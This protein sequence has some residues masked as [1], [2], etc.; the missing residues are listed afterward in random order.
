MKICAECKYFLMSEHRYNCNY[1]SKE[2]QNHITGEI[3]YE[4]KSC[5]E[6][7]CGGKCKYWEPKPKKKSLFERLFK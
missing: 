2:Y 4:Y 6:R 5:V 3:T 1:D 7:N